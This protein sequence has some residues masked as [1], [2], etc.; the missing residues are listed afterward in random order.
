MGDDESFQH[1]FRISWATLPT[2]LWALAFYPE[3][4]LQ[5]ET[6]SWGYLFDVLIGGRRV[7]TRLFR[8]ARKERDANHSHG[9]HLDEVLRPLPKYTQDFC[10][11]LVRSVA[12]WLI[13]S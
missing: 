9:V 12:A 5:D 3:G 7:S 13:L 2:W 11:T 6:S 10:R 4:G 8:L 1:Q